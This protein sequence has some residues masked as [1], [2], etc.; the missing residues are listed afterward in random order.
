M[1][2]LVEQ[3]Q[4]NL[5]REKSSIYKASVD[6]AKLGVLYSTDTGSLLLV[7]VCFLSTCH[8]FVSILVYLASESKLLAVSMDGCNCNVKE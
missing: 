7:L 8:H 4:A 2:L 3:L 1:A 5:N 6:I